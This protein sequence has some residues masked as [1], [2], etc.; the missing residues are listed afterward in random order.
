M[1]V[2]GDLLVAV[3]AVGALLAV[4]PRWVPLPLAKDLYG[5]GASVLSIVFSVY[6]A[7]LA[8]VISSSDDRFIKWL[9]EDGIFSDLL[10]GFKVTLLCLFSALVLAL[11]LYAWSGAQIAMDYRAQHR[12][13]VILFAGLLIYSLC[14]TL[15]TTLAAIKYAQKRSTFLSTAG[16]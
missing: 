3:A 6:F 15:S 5:I 14:A 10:W 4:V 13:G 8:I 7:A 1:L 9:E 2:S 12:S 11:A 16:S